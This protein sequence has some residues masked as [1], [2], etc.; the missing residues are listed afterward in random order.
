MDF[1]VNSQEKIGEKVGFVASY[2]IFTTILFFVLSFLHKIPEDWTIGHVAG[3][4]VGVIVVGLLV[5]K[6]LE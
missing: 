1:A 4:T 3:I 2:A 5:K 6:V